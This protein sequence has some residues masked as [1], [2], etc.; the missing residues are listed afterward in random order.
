MPRPGTEPWWQES[1]LALGGIPIPKKPGYGI[2]VRHVANFVGRQWASPLPF[3]GSVSGPLVVARY[4]DGR[5][6]KGT[7]VDVSPEKP[8]CHI[9]TPEGT[10]H[11][12]A[13]GDLKALFFVKTLDGNFEHNEAMEMEGSD[14]RSLG[15]AIVVV[16]FEDGEQLVGFSTR[17]P[18]RGSFYYV[19]PVDPKSNN[20]RA[21]VNQ[22]SVKAIH[23]L[24]TL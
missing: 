17:F 11:Q 5:L 2:C 19:T 12:I 6:I 1:P 9:L 14:R 18:P 15:A 24:V 8:I 3:H 13:L 20:V 10:F 7:S 23:N 4:R 22:A 21:L 16:I